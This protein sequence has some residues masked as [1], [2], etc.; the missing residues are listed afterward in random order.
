MKIS[1]AGGLGCHCPHVGKRPRV[2]LATIP[3]DDENVSTDD[4]EDMFMSEDIL[5]ICMSPDPPTSLFPQQE[6]DIMRLNSTRVSGLC[7]TF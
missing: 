6:R 7:Y 4:D 3:E 1:Q 2:A 5:S